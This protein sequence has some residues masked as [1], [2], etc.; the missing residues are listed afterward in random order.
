MIVTISGL[1]GTGKSTVGKM[2]SEKLGVKYY[3]TGQAFRELAEQKKMSL[4][5]FTDYVEDHPEI[6]LELDNKIIDIAKQGN[7]IVD[8]QIS[9]Y[10]LKDIADFKILLTCP[11]EIR[12]KRMADRDHSTLEEKI[13]ETFAREKSELE[14]F[15]KLYNIN[16]ENSKKNRQ[17]YDLIV[18]TEKLSADKVVEKILSEINEKLR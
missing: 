12:I 17:I 5:E 14:R 9:G 10:L 2:L 15:K 16:L 11:I 6:D 8:S 1:H 3:S 7:L 4:K 13:N 18:D